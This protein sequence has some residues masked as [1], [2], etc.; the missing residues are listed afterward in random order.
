MCKL[1]ARD[2]IEP[3]FYSTNKGQRFKILRILYKCYARGGE[4]NVRLSIVRRPLAPPPAGGVIASVVHDN[5]VK[6]SV[7]N[8]GPAIIS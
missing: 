3:I 2:S 7:V 5:A 8:D 4:S 6:L 1:F